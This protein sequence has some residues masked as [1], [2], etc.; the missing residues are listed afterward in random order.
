MKKVSWLFGLLIF[1]TPVLNAQ[2]GFYGALGGNINASYV[3]PQNTYGLEN[4]ELGYGFEAGYGANLRI[5]YNWHEMLGIG[6]EGG[7]LSGGQQYRDKIKLGPGQQRFQHDK[8]VRLNYVTITPLFRISPLLEKSLYKQ[9]HKLKFVLA[10]GPQIG[11]LTGATVD[12]QI[13]EK[14]VEYPLPGISAY[15]PVTDDKELFQKLSVNFL[16]DIGFDWYISERWYINPSLRG[17]ISMTDINASDYR[18]HSGYEASH[19]FMAG[20]QV[21]AGY[22]FVRK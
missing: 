3:T 18:S 22:F 12:Y 20:L 15:P 8:L 13:D 17:Q 11:I 19:L 5:G 2:E 9:E 4:A 7:Y 10:F 6:L 16:L 1:S 14:D 21:S